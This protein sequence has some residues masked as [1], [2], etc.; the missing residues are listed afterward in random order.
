MS[1]VFAAVGVTLILLVFGVLDARRIGRA[2]G[3][4][5]S[6]DIGLMAST[7]LLVWAIA[8]SVAGLVL[9]PAA[10]APEARI[11]LIGA[12]LVFGAAVLILRREAH[13]TTHDFRGG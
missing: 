8:L 4:C 1:F 5:A 12:D 6:R 13:R 3:D 10:H 7:R 9:V 2:H 11:A